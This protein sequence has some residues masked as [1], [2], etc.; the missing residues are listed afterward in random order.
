LFPGLFV[1]LLFFA[2]GLGLYVELRPETSQ[3]IWYA[4]IEARCTYGP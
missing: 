3:R 1:A 4:Q 2:H